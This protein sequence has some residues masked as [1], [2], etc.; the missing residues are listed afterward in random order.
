M[1][2]AQAKQPK[3]PSLLMIGLDAADC[4]FIEAHIKTL[5]NIARIMNGS[6]LKRL[7][8]EPLSGSV[9]TTFSTES[10]PA[11]H[12]VYHH[13]QWDPKQMKVR[14]THP[15][16]VG[17]IEPFWR[18]MARAGTSVVAFDVPFVFKGDA[19]GAVEIMNWGSHDIV[20][21]FWSN[22]AKATRIVTSVAARH[23]MGYELPLEKSRATLEHSLDGIL[24]GIA[25][26]AEATCDLMAAFD[27]DLFI[28][29]FGESHR[30]GHLLWPE[31]EDPQTEVPPD[32][33]LSVYA[34]LDAAVGRLVEA[35][36]PDTTVMLFALHGMAA[37]QSQS[38]LSSAML[39][40]ALTHS[41]SETEPE[42]TSFGLIRALRR[43][44]PVSLQYGIARAVPVA[45][46]DFVVAREI[47]GGYRWHETKAISLDGDLSGYWRA[48]VAGRETAGIVEDPQEFVR[49]LAEDLAVFRTD[50]G[51]PLVRSTL[52]PT[53]EWTGARTQMLPD[54]VLE[55]NE[56]LTSVD[57][58]VS[59]TGIRIAG[60]RSTGRSGNHRFRGFVSHTG[61]KDIPLPNHIDGLGDLARMLLR[62][63]G[64]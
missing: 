58:A 21:R 63:S 25:L 33:L 50:E 64:A 23:P 12:G 22:N 2:T 40:T 8:V 59:G 35:A 48:N 34:A 56:D 24:S 4:A 11:D 13:M 37:N 7:K 27:S 19:G 52:L 41:K 57:A 39:R 45:V 17:P 15:D 53:A 60:S 26:K 49:Q 6:A 5:P 30:A 51:T 3:D 54:I 10:R 9:W 55:W 18:D 47:A 14:R 36:G 42:S 29:V 16:W 43:S 46:R 31:P 32:A 61:A 28:V 44:V 62:A 20:D 1:S 38:H